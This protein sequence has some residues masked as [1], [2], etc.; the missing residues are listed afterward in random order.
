MSRIIL[1]PT[2]NLVALEHYRNTIEN[3]VSISLIEK[4]GNVKYVF[5]G[6]FNENRESS[7]SNI[8][9]FVASAASEGNSCYRV[10]VLK[11][12][13]NKEYDIFSQIVRF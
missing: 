12:L 3:P 13:N 9:H 5:T 8:T 6:H 10:V 4:Y 1:Q 7:I 2:S 11:S